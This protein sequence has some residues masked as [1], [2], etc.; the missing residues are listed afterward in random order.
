VIKRV[1][2]T[3]LTLVALGGALAAVG[4]I[5]AAGST[6]TTTYSACLT[7]IG[8]LL[9]D[10][11][12]D[13][14]PKCEGDRVVSWD[15]VGLPGPAGPTG[16]TGPKGNDGKSVLTGLS[17]PSG[18]CLQGTTY[19]EVLT[20]SGEVYRCTAKSSWEDTGNNVL[21]PTGPS[22]LSGSPGPPGATGNTGAS[23][24][25]GPPGASG[26]TGAT[27]QRGL[28]GATGPRGATG[29]PGPA[30][31]PGATGPTGA[32]RAGTIYG[33]QQVSGSEQLADPSTTSTLAS[34]PDGKGVVSGS[35]YLS[36]SA[37]D[38]GAPLP[39]VLQGDDD[40]QWTS[41]AEIFLGQYVGLEAAD[42]ALDVGWDIVCA[43]VSGVDGP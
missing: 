41:S 4:R 12:A 19:I 3:V 7:K 27:G 43:Y 40:G 42:G 18:K 26:P 6:P 37:L 5:A 38:S 36:N 8:G 1:A 28:T 32:L 15:Q 39:L 10:V 11:T 21:G 33:A 25:P 14:T 34:C 20:G 35:A 24:A 22:G 13:G 17:V 16:P 29:Q 2:M 9:Y 30:G 23:G 31:V